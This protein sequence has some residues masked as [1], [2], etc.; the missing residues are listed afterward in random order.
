MHKSKAS[1]WYPARRERP[2]GVGDWTSS[3]RPSHSSMA[4]R[5]LR[6]DHGSARIKSSPKSD[7]LEFE[8][9]RNWRQAALIHHRRR[10]ARLSPARR[11]GTERL[12]AADGR[13]LSRK[14]EDHLLL[15]EGCHLRMPDRNR[16]VRAAV[17]GFRRPRRRRA[18]RLDR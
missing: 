18:R 10:K 15:P 2:V 13:E 9:A 11:E 17:E 16:R 7:P 1:R 6:E 4:Y 5:L 14:V 8:D 3:P 12:R